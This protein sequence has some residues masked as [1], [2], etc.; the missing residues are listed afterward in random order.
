MYARNAIYQTFD[1]DDERITTTTA[2]TTGEHEKVSQALQ[3]S[4]HLKLQ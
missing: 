4:G 3:P 1:V 2:A